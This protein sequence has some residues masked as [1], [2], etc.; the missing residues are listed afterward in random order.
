[1]GGL[2]KNLSICEGGWSGWSGAEVDVF[3]GIQAVFF[4]FGFAQCTDKGVYF[5]GKASLLQAVWVVAAIDAYMVNLSKELLALVGVGDSGVFEGDGA[6]GVNGDLEDCPCAGF[7]DAV[8]FLHSGVVVG[9]VF[10]DV[11]A[12]DG[13][14]GLVGV[15]EGGYVGFECDVGCHEVGGGVGDGGVLFEHVAHGLV[16]GQ[17]EEAVGGG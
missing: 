9:D 2:S 13:V 17:V 14:E 1:M 12:E 16:G 7:E 6:G 11:V 8:E 3:G 15:G 10:E 5:H 4:L